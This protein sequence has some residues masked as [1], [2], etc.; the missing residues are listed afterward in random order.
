MR[1]W[2]FKRIIK[3]ILR[4]LISP[5]SLCFKIN[6]DKDNFLQC[7]AQTASLIPGDIGIIIRREIMFF[8]LDHTDDSV[9][10]N[11]GTIFSRINCE[12]NKNVYIGAYCCI[13]SVC[14]KKDTIIGDHVSI[15][16]GKHQHFF[17]DLASPVRTQKG[18][19]KKIIIGEDCWIGSHSIIMA[20][21]GK[22][23]IV[24]AGSVVL[25]NFEDYCIIAGN[26]AKLIR[27]RIF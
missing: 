7:V 11:F 3:W 25:N 19:L 17:S 20:D 2:K 13:G 5:I 22:K 23:C 4:F 26:P 18:E 14:I 27:K 12:L 21:I 9:V 16:S 1:K 15:L 6:K 24:G 10:I 8:L